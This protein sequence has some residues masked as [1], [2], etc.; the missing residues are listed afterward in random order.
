MTDARPS[1]FVDARTPSSTGRASNA[2]RLRASVGHHDPIEFQSILGVLVDTSHAVVC[3]SR[4]IGPKLSEAAAD[5]SPQS[6]PGT[7]SFLLA[8]SRPSVLR[9]CTALDDTTQYMLSTV[10][11]TNS[12]ALFGQISNRRSDHRTPLRRLKNGGFSYGNTLRTDSC[13]PGTNFQI[14]ADSRQ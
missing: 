6:R 10:S 11:T 14:E 5:V 2:P 4:W 9:R 8:P 12:S 1:I 13:Q 3:S 7:R